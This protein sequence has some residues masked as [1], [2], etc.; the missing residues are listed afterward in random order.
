MIL[1]TVLTMTTSFKKDNVYW[2]HIGEQL[3]SI[4]NGLLA[5]T[6]LSYSVTIVHS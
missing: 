3:I 4:V 5:K 6:A 2:A 1:I